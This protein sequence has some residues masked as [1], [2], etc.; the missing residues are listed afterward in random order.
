MIVSVTGGS[1]PPLYCYTENA[2]LTSSKNFFFHFFQNFFSDFCLVIFIYFLDLL[3]TLINNLQELPIY[4]LFCL[5]V[6]LFS[7]F[8]L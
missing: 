4:L 2:R 8:L 6:V 3:F 5:E 7:L 1:T